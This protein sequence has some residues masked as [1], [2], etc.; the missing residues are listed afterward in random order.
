MLRDAFLENQTEA[1]FKTVC[2]PKVTGTKILDTLSR[3][4]CPEL[5]YF[6]AFS[7][8]SC[9]RGNAG[10]TN[11][12]LANSAMERICEDRQASG[13]PGVAIQWGAIGDVGL[14]LE[15]MG[16]N[17]TVVGGTLPQRMNSCLATMDN[18]LQQPHPVLASMVLAE[19]RRGGDTGSQVGLL[20]AVGNI[21][22]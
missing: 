12:G 1:D 14:V 15:T 6:V 5:D 17:E 4:L 7:S 3:E 21:L 19:K 9:G 11:Y 18:F 10:Q 13:L 2:L 22:G 8:L 16:D 20:N